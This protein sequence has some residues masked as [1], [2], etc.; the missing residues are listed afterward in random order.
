[1]LFPEI[2]KAGGGEQV[3]R[4]TSKRDQMNLQRLAESTATYHMGPKSSGSSSSCSRKP[5]GLRD[6]WGL[7]QNPCGWAGPA[8]WASARCSQ[9]RPPALG[10]LLVQSP[11]IAI[12]KCVVDS[13]QGLPCFLLHGALQ[14]VQL[15]LL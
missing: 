11:V 7:R 10:R 6:K 4:D 1:M 5:C 3:C 14:I 13:E 9:T 15:V 8:L 12:L 2:G